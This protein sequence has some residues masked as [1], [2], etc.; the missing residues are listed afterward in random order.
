MSLQEELELLN[1][2][3]ESR[4]ASRMSLTSNNS[5][6]TDNENICYKGEEKQEW[7]DSIA[8][9]NNLHETVF[10]K[11]LDQHLGGGWKR[12]NS[13]FPVIQ[14]FNLAELDPGFKAFGF[15]ER[16]KLLI[17]PDKADRNESSA[18]A[19]IQ[20]TEKFMKILDSRVKVH[21]VFETIM[22]ES[23]EV[24]SKEFNSSVLLMK[25]KAK[26]SSGS[27]QENHEE[28]IIARASAFQE[29]KSKLLASIQLFKNASCCLA[30]EEGM[31]FTEKFNK[32]EYLNYHVFEKKFVINNRKYDEYFQEQ[33]ALWTDLLSS[34]GE[35]S[36][37]T[38]TPLKQRS[39]VSRQDDKEAESNKKEVAMIN[40]K[41]KLLKEICEETESELSEAPLDE[42][43]DNLREIKKLH[44]E[45][46]GE[47][48]DEHIELTDRA[49]DYVASRKFLIRKIA[50]R[51]SEI[52]KTESERI[53]E[54]QK[55]E[56]RESE[57]RRNE[58]TANIRTM[59]AVKLVP[60]TGPEDFIAWKKNQKF[61]NTH[62]DPYKKAAAL[63]G[64]LRNPED[65]EMCE[66]IYDFDKLMS[67]LNDKYNHQEM[68]IPTLKNKLDQL[69]K[70]LNNEMM[71]KNHRTSL[72]V[73][74]QLKELGA[75]SFFD[76]T[77]IFNLTQKF[78]MEAKIDFERF[79]KIQ[80]RFENVTINDQTFDDDG[81]AEDSVE[82][83]KQPMDLEFIDNSPEHRK[84]F[85]H[86]I[87]EEAKLLEYTREKGTCGKCRKAFCVCIITPKPKVRLYNVDATE[88]CPCCN[89]EE[90]HLNN[91]GKPT[92]SI[93]RCPVFRDM[94]LDKRKEFAKVSKACYVCLIP[95]HSA[96]VCSIKTNCKKCKDER[97]H[98]QL[99]GI[100]DQKD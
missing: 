14:G 37:V 12:V 2:Y 35:D 22:S 100:Y 19:V 98:P 79:K 45:V 18:L 68:L 51:I 60:L 70:A 81:Y 84:Y 30:E 53:A 71:L 44:C 95:G 17:D 73:Y 77:V 28:N 69:P 27:E 52:Q 26:K 32:N 92:S 62:T 11:I 48:Y 82:K 96:K 93:G 38:S 63:L 42:L 54:I 7:K 1:S 91:F 40:K 43:Q 33:E 90:P 57:I 41:L 47:M 76:G 23:I 34:L 86:Y 15:V 85:L 3:L 4:E 50:D 87:R 24:S 72:N 39:Q 16:E 78:T 46:R 74:E 55:T 20:S 5:E 83:K 80:K 66:C 21:G 8:A 6:E 36:I 59:E 9:L 13:D 99:C 58:I 75:T 94:T 88:V 31:G 29:N 61:L 89:S 65:K 67:I 56:A 10:P 49:K 97:H 25:L 64:T